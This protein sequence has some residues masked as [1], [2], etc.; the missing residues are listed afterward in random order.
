MSCE[1]VIVLSL[2]WSY[3]ILWIDDLWHFSSRSFGVAEVPW[4]YLLTLACCG[5]SVP[6]KGKRNSNYSLSTRITKETS[7]IS[8]IW[9]RSAMACSYF[10]A[11][12]LQLSSFVASNAF[13]VY[14]LLSSCFRKLH[15]NFIWTS[16]IRS[17]FEHSCVQVFFLF[18]FTCFSHLPLQVFLSL[19]VFLISLCLEAWKKARCRSRRLGGAHSGIPSWQ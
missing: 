13:L 9:Q 1:Y 4:L 17:S 19:H 15:M 7:A 6:S 14:F 2:K 3:V 12:Q 10:V 8:C 5:G 16:L 18:L 11:Q